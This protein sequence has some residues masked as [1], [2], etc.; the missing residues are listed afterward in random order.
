MKNHP[1]ASPIIPLFKS[2]VSDISD[3]Y[4]HP[5]KKSLIWRIVIL[6]FF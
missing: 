1:T 2:L 4:F 3:T 6:A 5:G